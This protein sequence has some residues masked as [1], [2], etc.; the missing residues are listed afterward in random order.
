MNRAD[1][2]MADE[3]PTLAPPLAKRRRWRQFSL[4]AFLIFVA[5]VACIAAWVGMQ[6]T[7]RQSE[8]AAIEHLTKGGS[9]S[10]YWT[11]RFDQ[12]PTSD[13][14]LAN[15]VWPRGKSGIVNRLRNIDM[16]RTVVLFAFHPNGNTF[17]FDADDQGN[18]RIK[19]EYKSGLRDSDME[20]VARLV[21]LRS[22]WLEA[23]GISDDGLKRLHNLS[24]LEILWIQHT[25]VTD[26]GIAAM[27]NL[28]RLSDL[29]LSGTE[30][31][32]ESVDVLRKCRRLKH[33]GLKNT[34]V[35][36]HGIEALH[37]ELPDCVI[38]H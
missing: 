26:A 23:N 1:P 22:L 36:L 29:D 33:L 35:S 16:F 28:T 31:S 20:W 10:T 25:A 3:I 7:R 15:T 13:L 8:G 34:H 21:N 32:D 14:N 2:F 17:T 5:I 37:R 19:R 4:R 30:V 9:T 38:E 11:S 27:S 24:H 12:P 6:I 18:L